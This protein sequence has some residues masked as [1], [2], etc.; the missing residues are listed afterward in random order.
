MF[1]AIPL[2][3]PAI[4]KAL[5]AAS[6]SAAAT[7]SAV[8]VPESAVGT[9]AGSYG[10]GLGGAGVSAEV[11]RAASVGGMSVPQSWGTAA[12]AI[13]LAATALPAAGLDGLPEAGAAG[14]GGWFGGMPPV[15]SVVNAPRN[16]APGPRYES[17]LKVIPQMVA[18]PGV[19]EG[20]LDRGVKPD[21]RGLDAANALS[22]RE[23]DELDE[24][25]KE[26]SD[27]AMERDAAARLIKE[28]IR[29]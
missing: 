25:R 22:E 20:T 11:G 7:A 21:G 14:P 15:G 24:L 27:L 26:I 18:A 3:T 19:Y 17:R 2:A 5:A 12:P 13:R 23:R 1:F 8:A 16:G 4:G 9:L 6:A 29:R 10:S 28:A